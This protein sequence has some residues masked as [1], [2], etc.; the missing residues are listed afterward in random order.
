LL[1]CLVIFLWLLCL[2]GCLAVRPADAAELYLDFSGAKLGQL[3]AGYR[4]AVTGEGKPGEWKVVEDAGKT[5]SVASNA[6]VSVVPRY[7]VL[8]QLSRD[9]TDEHFPVLIYEGEKFGDF[10]L[11]TRFKIVD[12]AVEQMAGIAFRIQDPSSYY[13]G[14][15][16]AL[17]NNFRFYKFVGGLRSPPL[18]PE[19]EIARGVWHDLTVACEGNHLRCVL[20]GKEVF[21]GND[22]SFSDGYIGFW[23]KS[24]TV[25]YFG[26]TRVV[27]TPKVT[28]AETLVRGTLEA[29]ARLLGLKIFGTRRGIQGLQVLASDD[30]VEV[31]QPASEAERDAIAR[32]VVYC[33]RG[34]KETFVTLPL[35]DRNGDAVAAVRV[36]LSSFPGQTDQTAVARAR[37]IAKEIERHILAAKDL[38][39]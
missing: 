10:T 3:P 22:N 6:T 36:V 12:G 4:S 35:H 23:T 5:P 28:L 1:F 38:T 18:G 27:F 25:G 34:R 20:D 32:N 11:T 2:V 17:G 8:A 7:P 21:S 13:V 30:P 31:G 24:D 9:T 26:D 33:G 15:A 14:R 16:S 37:P 19:M 29:H 39:E